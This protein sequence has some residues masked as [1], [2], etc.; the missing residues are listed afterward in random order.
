MYVGLRGFRASRIPTETLKIRRFGA[1]ALVAFLGLRVSRFGIAVRL[2]G[3]GFLGAWMYSDPLIKRTCA[4]A[5]ST[6]AG[7][8]P[9]KSAP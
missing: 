9:S 4:W 2:Q 1:L 8:S 5:A 6:V 7:S 3:F